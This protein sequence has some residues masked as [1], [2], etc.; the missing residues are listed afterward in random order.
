MEWISVK[1]K[2]PLDRQAVIFYVKD[3]EDCFCGFFEKIPTHRN[4]ESNRR[5]IF[6]ENLDDWWF[7]DE[8]VTHWMPLPPPP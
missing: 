4:I 2:W 3:R 5:N 7:E 6:Y 1:D 8:E